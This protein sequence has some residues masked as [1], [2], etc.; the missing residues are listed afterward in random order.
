MITAMYSQVC[1]SHAGLAASPV[2]AGES[3]RLGL[4]N[5]TSHL[6]LRL[7]ETSLFS[8]RRC[9]VRP[10]S[11]VG[12]GCRD[13][14][15]LWSYW[16][17]PDR[18]RGGA[19][20]RRRGAERGIPRLPR[21]PRGRRRDRRAAGRA[22][23]G[24]GPGGRARRGRVADALA[25]PD[26]RRGCRRR[27]RHGGDGCRAPPTHFSR[28]RWRSWTRRRSISS[29]SCAPTASASPIPT[30]TRSASTYLGT[31]ADAVAGGTVTEEFTGTLGPSVRTRRAGRRR[32]RG[33][34]AR[35]GGRDGRQRLGTG[36]GAASVRASASRSPS[37][38]SARP[39]RWLARRL[40]RRIAGDL[41][42]SAVRDAVSSYE[43][44][45]TLGEALRAQTHEHG[46]RM[47][48]AVAL[49]E[50]GRD[51]RGDGHPRPRR[52]G[53]ARS[54]SIRWPRA[55]TATRP[56]ARSCS[57]RRR[58]RRS[59]AS[60][61]PPRSTRGIP[62][63]DAEPGRRRLGRRQPHRQR[64]R[65]GG[66]RSRS[67]AGCEVGIAP[68][69]AATSCSPC[70]RQRCRRAGRACASASSSTASHQAGGR[71]TAAAS[72]SPWCGRSSRRAAGRST[73]SRTADDL[74]GHPSRKAS[75][76]RRAHRR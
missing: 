66:R 6:R 19:W 60:S 14:A 69:P 5:L 55:A 65:C 9:G 49:L 53:R 36:L 17:R 11:T 45:R 29:R 33:R 73:L 34:R 12:H 35:R 20:L 75:H 44:V 23:R 24:R 37:Q 32:R 56:S 28:S 72:D 3:E 16:S 40:T 4:G 1:L 62:R 10:A 67:R 8:G 52:R 30:P 26:D 48:T 25:R 7:G 57:A 2:V 18:T 54:S 31:I 47:H 39:P 70:P 68:A 76:D 41:P 71:P 61:G 51:G 13:E 46:N 21:L 38:P 59:A 15:G 63:S 74:P 58:R 64:A 27:R 22:A 50:L 43:S 42:A